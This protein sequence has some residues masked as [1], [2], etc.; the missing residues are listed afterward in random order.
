MQKR[1]LIKWGLLIAAMCLLFGGR[2]LYSQRSHFIAAEE[3]YSAADWK[4]AIREYDSALHFY[5]PWSPYIGKSASR[6]W[7]IGEM[8]EKAGKPD[9]A[10]LAYSSIRSSF[11]ASRSLYTPG[12]SW[13]NRCDDK[14]AS[15]N[16][17]VLVKEGSL[18]PLQAE[19]EKEKYL[20]VLK[21]DRAPDPVWSALVEA[22]FFGW[23]ISVLYII[24]KAFDDSGRLLMRP[25]LY[26][27]LSFVITFGVW[28]ISLLKA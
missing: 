3:Y 5:T 25:A 18:S 4:L 13:I 26:G 20:H 23:I 8:F 6:L 12:Q 28:V 14:I 16:V 9:W 19:E 27:L 22:G 11:Y 2:V 1:Y 10:M 17:A 7:Q 15:L 24:R 21:V